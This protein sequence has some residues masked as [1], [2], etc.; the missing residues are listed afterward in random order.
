[1]IIPATFDHRG[2]GEI[3]LYLGHAYQMNV[4]AGTPSHVARWCA[5]R[6]TKAMLDRTA[7]KEATTS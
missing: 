2:R 3:W 7:P 5:I 6:D 1:M 4:K